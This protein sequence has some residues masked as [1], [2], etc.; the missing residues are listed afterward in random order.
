MLTEFLNVVLLA[1]QIMLKPRLQKLL[2][3]TLGTILCCQD[4]L[5][6]ELASHFLASLL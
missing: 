6:T 5:M 3:N 1:V 4:G 2:E